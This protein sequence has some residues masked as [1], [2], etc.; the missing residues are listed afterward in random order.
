MKRLIIM[1]PQNLPT[2]KPIK[3]IIIHL[4]IHFA[5]LCT[6]LLFFKFIIFIFSIIELRF[7]HSLFCPRP[8]SR[9]MP[10][11]RRVIVM[12][13]NILL[14]SVIIIVWDVYKICLRLFYWHRVRGH[15]AH[16][17][18]RTRQPYKCGRKVYSAIQICPVRRQWAYTIAIPYIYICLAKD[19]GMRKQPPGT[20][21]YYYRERPWN[22]RTFL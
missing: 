14:C 9:E 17:V 8:I 16:P 20:T 12:Y 15:M 18:Y 22:R 10:W 13:P 21:Y 3:N 6:Y 2:Q 1:W 7:L 19:E 4:Y 11:S 5:I